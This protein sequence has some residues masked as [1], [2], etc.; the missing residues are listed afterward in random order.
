MGCEGICIL[1]VQM[2]QA[3]SPAALS[4]KWGWGQYPIHKLLCGLSFWARHIPGSCQGNCANQ[5]GYSGGWFNLSHLDIYHIIG[6]HSILVC[7]LHRVCK[8]MDV[9]CRCGRLHRLPCSDRGLALRTPN[10]PQIAWK[11]IIDFPPLSD[12]PKM[13]PKNLRTPLYLK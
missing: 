12:R 6:M 2:A 9:L 10:W 4:A 5:Y 8:T 13:N 7:V 11:N 3:S 1:E